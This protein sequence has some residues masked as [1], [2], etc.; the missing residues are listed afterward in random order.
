MVLL[1]DSDE[2]EDEDMVLQS[3]SE[4]T[5]S[6]PREDHTDASSV[7][8]TS[9]RPRRNAVR[10][11]ANST[12]NPKVVQEAP[13]GRRRTTRSVSACSQGSQYQPPKDHEVKVKSRRRSAAS[14][15]EYA[16]LLI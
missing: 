12:S 14:L 11:R 2:E 1:Q 5:S 13:D 3:G 7:E 15:S 6:E 9:S 4:G 16:N 10:R 8:V